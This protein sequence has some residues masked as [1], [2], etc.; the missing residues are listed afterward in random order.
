MVQGASG[1]ILYREAEESDAA[2][3]TEL[4]RTAYGEGYVHPQVYDS[5]EVKRMIFDP[6]ALILVAEGR[7]S[8]T[9]VGTASVLYE[10][11]AYSDLVGEFGRLVVH[12]DWRARGIGRRLM[13]ER[14]ARVGHR[15]HVGFVEVRV[16]SSHSAR[17]SQAH[18]FVPVGA[19]PQKLVYGGEREHTA[20]LVR[21]FGEALRLRRNHPRI[22]PEA[23][24]L[25]ET[26]LR[27]AGVVPDAIIDEEAAPYPRGTRYEIEELTANG[28]SALLRIERGRIR[29]REIFGPQRLHYG[30]FRLEASDSHY[31]VA[32]RE[33]RVEGA[34]GY[35]KDEVERHARV[36]EVISVEDEVVHAL[37]EALA[38]RCEEEGLMGAEVDVNAHATRM[39]R[40]LLECGY[41][42]AAYVPAWTFHEVERLDV[43]KMYRLFEPLMDLPFDVPEPGLSLGHYVLERFHSLTLQPRIARA[44]ARLG[45]CEGLNHEQSRTLVAEFEPRT[46]PP[47][48]TIFSRGD[49]AE[50]M[51]LILEGRARVEASEGVVGGVGPGEC[52]GEVALLTGTP[53]SASAVAETE[54]EAGFLERE[55]LE[56]LVRRRP[57]IGTVVY[58][59]LA[60]G[61]GEKLRRAGGLDVR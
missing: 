37:F 33:G 1:E 13:K 30:L 8:G 32:R 40:T 4:F 50:G 27:G 26:A 45:V 10:M 61:L 59:N 46:V 47:G 22:V 35:M 53:H 18:G 31:V 48:T 16:G 52:L 9:I 19:L 51:L 49:D 7:S 57:D 11:G 29:N 6:D 56:T 42:P 21:H 5:R 58:R 15:L 3:V 2:A 12:P 60:R 24:R 38:A 17:I 55:G 14:L 20:L 54:L 34:L 28:Y 25:A 44:M 41:L 36:F 39:Q 23:D 43:V